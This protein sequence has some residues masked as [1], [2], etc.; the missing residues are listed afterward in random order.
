MVDYDASRLIHPTSLNEQVK[1]NQARFPGDFM[2]QLTSAEKQ[3]VIAICD[4]PSS[5]KFSSANPYVFTEHGAIL[6][7]IQ[8]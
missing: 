2:F 3:K 5:L 6:D 8:R 4:H 1:R 7:I